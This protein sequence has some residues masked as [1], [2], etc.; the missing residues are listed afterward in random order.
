M[1]IVVDIGNTNIKFGF[2]DGISLIKVIKMSTVKATVDEYLASLKSLLL[3]TDISLERIK[4]CYISS[5][6]PVVNSSLSIAIKKLTTITPIFLEVGV[7]TGVSVKVKN[8]SEVGADLISATAGAIS[9][10]I[11]PAVIVGIGTATT[12]TV[13]NDK[14]EIIGVSIAPGLEISKR[15]LTENT[16]LLTELELKI[17]KTVLGRT[18]VESMQSG[19]V[20]GHASMIDGM[21]QRIQAELNY[22]MPII[23][24]GGLVDLIVPVCKSAIKI[25]KNLLLN[26][27]NHIGGLNE[28]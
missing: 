5:V 10:G 4:S 7:K 11:Y 17:P 3:N 2:Y 27:L 25:D 26:G 14:K 13:V 12:F 22:N 24:F 20:F 18:T 6:V 16:S 9:K 28:K 21:I 15:S 19:I 1:N 8:P 23:A